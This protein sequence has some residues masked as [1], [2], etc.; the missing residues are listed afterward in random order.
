MF[1]E[2]HSLDKR[3][4]KPEYRT[5]ETMLG[6]DFHVLQ[7]AYTPGELDKLAKAM[8]SWEEAKQLLSVLAEARERLER[9]ERKEGA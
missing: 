4:K 3:R 7:D 5:L 2:T 9:K 1:L 6:A 8:T